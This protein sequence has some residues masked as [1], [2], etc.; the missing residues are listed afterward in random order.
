MMLCAG[1]RIVDATG[2]LKAVQ[3]LLGH[4]SI[5]TTADTYTDWDV[6]QLEASLLE[7]FAAEDDGE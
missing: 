6:H 5:A 4:A 1:T 3:A 2:N 7:T